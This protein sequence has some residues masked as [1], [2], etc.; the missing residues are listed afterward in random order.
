MKDVWNLPSKNN[1]VFHGNDTTCRDH[2]SSGDDLITKGYNVVNF[3]L[4]HD[5]SCSVDLD[6]SLPSLDA[7]VTVGQVETEGFMDTILEEDLTNGT[8]DHVVD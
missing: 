8:N 2:P 3:L 7:V 4:V 6:D 5:M 1:G